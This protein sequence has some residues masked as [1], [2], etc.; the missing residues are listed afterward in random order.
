MS[1]GSGVSEGSGGVGGSSIG[2]LGNDRGGNSDLS[3][4]GVVDGG[5]WGRGSSSGF[6][7]GDG[8]TETSGI[9]NVVY[10]TE[11]T[12]S[13]S[14]SI[15]SNLVVMCVRLLVTRLLGSV[16]IDGVVSERVGLRS[17]DGL[18]NLGIDGG[19]YLGV[20]RGSSGVCEG[21]SVSTVSV[22]GSS[23]I[24]SSVGGDGGGSSEESKGEGGLK[25]CTI[26]LSLN[27]TLILSLMFSLWELRE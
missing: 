3:N 24:L 22:G 14:E 5:S 7:G 10:L 25:N 1:V 15:R 26:S 23:S 4:G 21:S 19:G 13:I 11:D 18:S 6:V 20:S 17:I 9:G 27:I 12:T 16:F 2:S 8:G